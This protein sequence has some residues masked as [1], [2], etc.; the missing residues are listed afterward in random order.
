MLLHQIFYILKNLSSC[1]NVLSFFR[2]H[3][4][5][6]LSFFFKFFFLSLQTITI[7]LTL[8]FSFSLISLSQ[9]L[10]LVG[11]MGL[12]DCKWVVGPTVVGPTVVGVG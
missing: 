5:K 12:D 2:A 4:S 3:C 7:T 11:L 8:S 9:I 1:Y 10:P 6:V